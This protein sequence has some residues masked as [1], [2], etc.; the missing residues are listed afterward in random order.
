MNAGSHLLGSD[1]LFIRVCLQAFSLCLDAESPGFGPLIFSLD[2][3]AVARLLSRTLE[4]YPILC[5]QETPTKYPIPG[6]IG[7][8]DVR[9]FGIWDGKPEVTTTFLL[10]NC[11]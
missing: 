10:F 1:F 6:Q 4:K 2:C 9:L 5:F 8:F 7:K 11:A 3:I